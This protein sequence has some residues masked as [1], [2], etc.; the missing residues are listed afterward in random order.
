MTRRERVLGSVLGVAFA[1]AAIYLGVQKMF[2]ERKAR[3]ERDRIGF[4][5][6][7]DDLKE[8]NRKLAGTAK[9]IEGWAALTYDTDELR[10]STKIGATLRGLVARAGL[11]SNFSM[12][13]VRGK[14]AR[15]AYRE[16]G[17]T[18]R[19]R[20][21][22]EQIVDFLYLLRKEPHLHRLDSLVITPQPK[23]NE[24][25]VQVR[26]MALVLEDT[27]AKETDRLPTTRPTDLE[28][29]ERALYA[30]IP[31]R[32]L[33]RPYIQRQYTPPPRPTPT[34]PRPTPPRP[35][36]PRPGPKP[37]AP[38]PV[39]D[40][41]RFRIVGL[42]EVGQRSE[43]LVSD[44]STGQLRKYERGAELGGGVIA[45]VDYRPLPSPKNPKLLS[46]SRVILQVGPDYWAIELGQTLTEKRRLKSD[47]LPGSIRTP[48]DDAPGDMVKKND[49]VE[50]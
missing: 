40:P 25:D 20:G 42:P 39:V 31:N 24:V 48:S 29:E 14:R 43:V 4:S 45:M 8:E 1:G 2:L 23:T 15:G 32:D 34:P 12:Q 13:P 5:G 44:K 22:M 28:S 47:Q 17:R 38:K 33:F 11:E 26:Y 46:P 27:A 10:A 35:T 7:L 36:P 50:R 49:P 16:I 37:P 21:K 30:A 9:S 18:V 41:G 3:Y 19:V 6:K